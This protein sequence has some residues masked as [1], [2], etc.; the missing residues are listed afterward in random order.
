MNEHNFLSVVIKDCI[1]IGTRLGTKLVSMHQKMEL[2]G[3]LVGVV[4]PPQLL[5]QFRWSA[6]ER[7][8]VSN[9]YALPK[10]GLKMRYQDI[11]C[12]FK[13]L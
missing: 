1:L 4:S 8:E 7:L 2:G 12:L 10:N 9:A 5:S 3:V 11:F 6:K 13:I